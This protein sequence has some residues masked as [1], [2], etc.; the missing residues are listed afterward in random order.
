[1]AVAG[2]L[3]GADKAAIFLMALGE[4]T[5]AEVMK[6]LGP[7]DVQSIGAAMSGLDKVSKE[8]VEADDERLCRGKCKSKTAIGIGSERLYSHRVK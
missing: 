2:K 7:R 5:A 4:Q 1:M 3:N 6:H 8:M